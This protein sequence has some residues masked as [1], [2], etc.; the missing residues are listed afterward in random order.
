MRLKA[1]T[2]IFHLERTVISESFLD[3]R[4]H[5]LDNL[6]FGHMHLG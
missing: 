3:Q 5:N 4:S 6:D 2:L 1:N